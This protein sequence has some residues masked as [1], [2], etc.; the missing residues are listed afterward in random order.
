MLFRRLSQLTGDP[1]RLI[2]SL[3]SQVELAF[4]R[5]EDTNPYLGG[6]RV[7]FSF[8]AG[9]QTKTFPHSLGRKT[10]VNL[11]IGLMSMSD[12][13]QFIQVQSSDSSSIT[14]ARNTSS[15]TL[16]GVMWVW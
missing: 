5:L 3:Q 1:K 9:E 2:G 6:V 15:G 16:D 11:D 7:T 13:D 4:R 8:A 12:L 10:N 14:I